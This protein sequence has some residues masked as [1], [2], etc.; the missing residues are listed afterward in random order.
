MGL[1][2]QYVRNEN[3]WAEERRASARRGRGGAPALAGVPMVSHVG[4]VWRR[5]RK[6]G[7]RSAPLVPV[8]FAPHNL[9]TENC[10]IILGPLL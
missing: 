4:W 5:R 10:G 3:N 2:W 7:A 8:G 9:D 1:A 6:G